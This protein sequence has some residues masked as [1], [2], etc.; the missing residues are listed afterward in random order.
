MQRRGAPGA[1]LVWP[2][3]AVLQDAVQESHRTPEGRTLVGDTCLF[4]GTHI[5]P[6]LQRGVIFYPPQVC[7][8]HLV[9]GGPVGRLGL[10]RQALHLGLDLCDIDFTG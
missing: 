10:V 9:Q 7:V 6:G 1:Y 2:A 4:P 3:A 8:C 5:I